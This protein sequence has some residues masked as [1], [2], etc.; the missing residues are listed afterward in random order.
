MLPCTSR[1]TLSQPGLMMASRCRWGWTISDTSCWYISSWTIWARQREPVAASLVPL[2]VTPTLSEEDL[3]ILGLTLETSLVSSRE[4]EIL[5]PWP[6]ASPSS[7]PRHTRILRYVHDIMSHKKSEQA[8]FQDGFLLFLFSN[9]KIIVLL[10]RS[11]TWW[12][13]Q[14]YTEGITMRLELFSRVCTPVAL[15]RP[16]SSVKSEVGSER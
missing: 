15:P 16:P 6:T 2:Q 7:V 9:E 5:S 8:Q 14:S 4:P 12:L 3:S 1:L 11:A 13:Y 10:H